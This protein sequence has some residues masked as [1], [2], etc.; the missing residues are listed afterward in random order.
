MEKIIL[1]SQSPRRKALLELAKL[2]FEIVA[3]SIR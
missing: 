2:P 1:A 3:K